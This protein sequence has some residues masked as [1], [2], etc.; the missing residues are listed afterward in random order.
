MSDPT[1]HVDS[2]AELAKEHGFT[3]G[4]AESLT[5]GA[6]S[7]ALAMGSEAADWYHGC[8]VSYSRAVK[9]D[10][11]GVTAEKLVTERCAR[12]MVEGAARVLEVDAAVST[13]GAGG[14]GTEEGNPPGTVHVGV[15]VR[16]ELTC[17]E[18]HLDGDPAE[19]VEAATERSLG[20][21]LEAMRA[22]LG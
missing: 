15:L 13:T 8:V 14:P 11:L 5:G 10:L 2:I 3:V 19:V 7:S 20:L 18:L 4:A 1:K 9:E 22:A 6:V 21:L 16:N 12:E 17:H